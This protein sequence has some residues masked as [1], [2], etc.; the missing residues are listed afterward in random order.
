MWL[1]RDSQRGNHPGARK[2]TLEW[3]RVLHSLGWNDAILGGGF[4]CF[5]FSPLLGEMIHCGSFLGP[6]AV[7][8]PFWTRDHVPGWT[9]CEGS[10]LV[11]PGVLDDLKH[12]RKMVGQEWWKPG[13][14]DWWIF[15]GFGGILNQF[16]PYLHTFKPQKIQFGDWWNIPILNTPK[17]EIWKEP[18]SPKV[19]RNWRLV[20]YSHSLILSCRWRRSLARFLGSKF[21]HTQEIAG[22]IF[23]DYENPLVSLNFR[24]KIRCWNFLGGLAARGGY[25]KF[26]WLDSKLPFFFTKDPILCCREIGGISSL[27]CLKGRSRGAT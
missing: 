16:L 10:N 2:K 19:Y 5:L 4:K 23:R 27:T 1:C 22:L 6:A 20:K 8:D 7:G 11:K 13:V 3:I 25:L 18:I 12:F 21:R 17:L 9:S 15:C 24:P 26:P 14:S